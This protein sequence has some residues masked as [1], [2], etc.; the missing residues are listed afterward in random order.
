MSAGKVVLLIFGTLAF[1]GVGTCAMCTL[2][3]G[4]AATAVEEDRKEREARVQEK[5]ET[6]K[7][8][9]A[10]DWAIVVSMLRENEASV[11]SSW[12]GSC[13]K[14]KGTVHAIDSGFGDEPIVRIQEG[15]LTLNSLRCE[16]QHP[17]KALKLSKGQ[18][19]TVW[20]IG[21]GEVLGSLTLKHCDW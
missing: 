6:C 7:E 8:V 4:G 17:E 2:A 20:G 18:T 3:I 16:P 14:I 10:V 12:K 9:G 5:L 11:V 19:L 21:G 13:V 1:M 15:D